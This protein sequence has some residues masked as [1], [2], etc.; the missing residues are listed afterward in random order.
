VLAI[1]ACAPESHNEPSSALTSTRL[2]AM[3]GP[4][5]SPL[6]LMGFYPRP[7]HDLAR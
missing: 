3:I 2:W 1:L 7:A 4:S 6:V 5:V